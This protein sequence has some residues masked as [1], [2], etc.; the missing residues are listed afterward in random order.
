MVRTMFPHDLVRAQHDWNRTYAALAA[1]RP[2]NTT[3]LRRRL[4]RLSV[5][6]F[7]H[8][9]WSTGR[10]RSPAARVALRQ[11]VH[12]QEQGEVWPR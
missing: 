9:F 5:E 10:G 3:V 8:P 11:H 12:A 4:L 7:W 2:G 1:P 6:V